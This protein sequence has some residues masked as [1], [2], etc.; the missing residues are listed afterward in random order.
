M[1]TNIFIPEV[2]SDAVNEK[3]GTTL[4]FG[5]VAFDA[6]SLCPEIATAGDIVHFPKIKRT[7]NVES[8][9]KGTALT[10]SVVDM[11]D[12]T[13]TIK[14][15]GSAFRIYDSEKA[16]I[17]GSVQD[18]IVQ[19]VVDAMSKKIDSDLAS[20]ID[21][22]VVYKSAVASATGITSAEIQTGMD[23][24]GD[25]VDTAS[26]AAIIINSR[27]RSDFMNMSEFVDTARTYQT[28]NN[29]IVINGVIGYYYG[30]PVIVTNNGTWDDTAKECKSY[31]VKRD[32]LGYIFQKNISIEESRQALLLATDV[33]ASSL[34]ATKLIDDTGVVLLRKSIA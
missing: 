24:F 13:A 1:A 28:S 23:N 14:Y 26:Y 29:G 30:V 8:V 10:P 33:V 4:R 7:A 9:V 34:Y 6:S 17:K 19:Q 12:S 11:S 32:A 18:Q 15:V 3:L 5:S 22:D 2:F 21:A 31:I 25:S 27:L 20:S 16:Q